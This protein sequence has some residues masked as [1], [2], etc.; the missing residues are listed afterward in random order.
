M[1]E[2]IVGATDHDKNNGIGKGSYSSER[3]TYTSKSHCKDPKEGQ[4]RE[5]GRWRDD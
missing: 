4:P 1:S 2:I 3:N 5:G